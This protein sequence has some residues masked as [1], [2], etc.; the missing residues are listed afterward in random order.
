MA[1]LPMPFGNPQTYAGHSGM[2]FPQA[3]GTAFRASG[4]GVVYH[5]NTTSRG[6][7]Q[8]W[9]RYD[10][11]PE[12]GYAHMD[13][14][15]GALPV[16]AR[17]S[18]GT[19]LGRVG[20]K[21][22]NS[23]GPHLH[24]EINGDAS[25]AGFW[26]NFDRS[27]VVG[28]GG[29][30]SNVSQDVKNQQAFLNSARGEKL[31]VDGVRGPATIAAFKRYQQFLKGRGWYSGSIDGIW[32]AG[33]QA[34]HAKYYAEI[35]TPKPPASGGGTLHGL[36]W[37]GIQRM[38]KAD[39]GYT[40]AIDNIPGKGSIAAFQRF[41]NAKGY[42]NL[43]VDGIDGVGTLKAAQTWLKKRWGYTGA[44]DGIRGA[45]TNAAWGR[46]EVANAQAYSRVN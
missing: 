29:G 25:S 35:N 4:P 39:F 33:T 6:G 23:T 21:G 43:G 17:V 38:L 10:G 14:F 5:R 12:V 11:G 24:V 15:T 27:R 18:E 2:D 9:V 20:S 3:R 37:R 19:V 36:P 31:T 44:I 32:G 45:G 13:S 46:A 40:G 22:L 7:N 41:M 42:G 34:A 1:K 30:G 16:G 26:R 28:Q 8:I